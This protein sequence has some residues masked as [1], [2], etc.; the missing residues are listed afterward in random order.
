MLESLKRVGHDLSSGVQRALV[1][2]AE[3]WRELRRRSGRAL[4]PFFGK[5]EEGDEPLSAD[6]F[7]RWGLL[8]GE[9]YDNDREV[10]VRLEV[11]GL[12]GR[13]IEVTAEHG[14]L[15]IR[16]EKRRERE[17]HGGRYYLAECAYGWFER[18]LP[19]PDNV[20]A[21]GARARYRHGVLTVR[22]PK[23]VPARRITVH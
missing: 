22:L 7:P 4:T 21:S 5:R 19:L 10:V 12:D 14:L 9:I 3:G 8:A 1:R 17:E 20:D 13:D 2:L 23:I 11:P 6:T 18:T 15:T 16:G